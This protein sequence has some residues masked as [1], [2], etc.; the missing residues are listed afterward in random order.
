MVAAARE[1]LDEQ[2]IGP[3]LPPG[4]DADTLAY[5]LIRVAES[6]LYSDVVAGSTPDVDKAVAVVRALLRAEAPPSGGRRGRR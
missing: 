5:T 1:L 2:G 4:L 3:G 6:F